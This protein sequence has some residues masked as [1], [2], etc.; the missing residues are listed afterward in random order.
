MTRA[1]SPRPSGCSP[2]RAR[3]A[4]RAGDNTPP[5]AEAGAAGCSV[6][7]YDPAADRIED[8]EVAAARVAEAASAAEGLVLT[9]RAENHITGVDDH[10]DTIARL[11]AY[12]EAG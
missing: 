8:V 9:A 10:D 11:V 3:R 4:R 1:A 12:R 6:E 2:R 7:D 5:P